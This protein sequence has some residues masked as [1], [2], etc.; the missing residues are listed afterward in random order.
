VTMTHDGNKDRK[1][2]GINEYY[3]HDPRLPTVEVQRIWLYRCGQAVPVA[4][5]ISKGEPGESDS[6][7]WMWWGNREEDG[8]TEMQVSHLLPT[9]V[10]IPRPEP[11]EVDGKFLADPLYTE[12]MNPI[13]LVVPTDETVIKN[14]WLESV[15]WT[16]PGPSPYSSLKREELMRKTEEYKKTRPN[17]PKE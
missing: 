16:G 1:Y 15:I 14:Y 6:D 17:I 13:R 4:A 2:E 9:D 7:I 10:I 8:P 11:A 12:S 5:L 3:V